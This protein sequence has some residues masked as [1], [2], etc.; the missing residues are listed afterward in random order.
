VRADVNK[1]IRIFD[2]RRLNETA[3]RPWT[4]ERPVLIAWSRDDRVFP[5]EHAERLAKDLP[6]ARLE[7]IEG[8]RTLSMEDQPERLSELIADF[9][10][11]P[12]KAAV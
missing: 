3:D 6:N 7:W 10:R 5:T 4:F 11:E 8:S 12:E 9:V 2:K 1:M